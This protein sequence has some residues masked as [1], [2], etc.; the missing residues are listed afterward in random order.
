MS[1]DCF[2]PSRLVVLLTMVSFP[3]G[4]FEV[5]TTEMFVFPS[6]FYFY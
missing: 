3:I 2:Y 6:S 5:G 1:A 4:G